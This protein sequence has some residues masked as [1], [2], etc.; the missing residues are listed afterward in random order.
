MKL[1]S[2]P[3]IQEGKVMQDLDL[4][5]LA[6]EGDH[7]LGVKAAPIA[8]D[9]SSANNEQVLFLQ[10]QVKTTRNFKERIRLCAILAKID[11]HPIKSISSI[12]QISESTI[13]EYVNDFKKNK[14]TASKKHV[15][16]PCR[17]SKSQE[18]ELSN[19]IKEYSYKSIKH[20][21]LYIKKQYGLTYTHSGLRDWLKRKKIQKK[22]RRL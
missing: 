11:L 20:L 14:K 5:S 1:N 10:K 12:L 15:G 17:L 3:P 19:Y 2:E 22:L 8:T 6:R 18:I 7:S 13:Y 16:R 4:E 21:C 9:D